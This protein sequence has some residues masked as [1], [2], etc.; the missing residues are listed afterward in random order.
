MNISQP[1]QIKAGIRIAKPVA[2]VFEAIADPAHMSQYF[3]SRSS[4]RIR[5]FLQLA[6][7]T[8]ATYQEIPG[9]AMPGRSVLGGLELVLSARKY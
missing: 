5:P 6:N 4:G 1:L 2:E 9:V 3:I 8:D 7:L